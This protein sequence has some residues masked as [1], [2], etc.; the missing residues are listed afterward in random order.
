MTVLLE[1][2]GR[3]MRSLFEENKG[4]RIEVID[5]L[6]VYHDQGWALVLPM[7]KSRSF[8]SIAKPARKKKR[9]PSP[10]YTPVGLVSS[11]YKVNGQ[12]EVRS[13]RGETLPVGR[14]QANVES[15]DNPFPG[16][17]FFW[18][19]L[20]RIVVFT[21]RR[22]D[23]TS[24]NKCFERKELIRLLLSFWGCLQSGLLYALTC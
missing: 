15:L 22:K 11:N 6:K 17:S 21:G 14:C 23:F 5:G 13:L 10:V 2:K 7:P 4:K 3:I 12:N 9:K 16:F 8:R 1:D 19:L 20:D 24:R 18:L